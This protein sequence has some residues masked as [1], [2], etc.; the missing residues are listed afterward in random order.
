MYASFQDIVGSP[1]ESITHIHNHFVG[2][3]RHWNKCI[4][5]LSVFD[6]KSTNPILQKQRD[7]AEVL[8]RWY[9]TFKA[10]LKFPFTK[11]FS[12]LN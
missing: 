7:D 3:R 10:V 2:C 1:L 8:I 6:L 5:V 9:A 11:L 4:R 12:L